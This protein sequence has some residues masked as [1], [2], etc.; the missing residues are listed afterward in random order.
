MLCVPAVICGARLT[1]RLHELRRRWRSHAAG[2]EGLPSNHKVC[3]ITVCVCACAYIC[4]C[5]RAL[6]GLGSDRF[7]HVHFFQ[8]TG[9]QGRQ[10]SQTTT[11]LHI[12]RSLQQ[13][14]L[15]HIRTRPVCTVGINYYMCQ[16]THT[17]SIFS[18]TC[19]Y[20]MAGFITQ[21][22]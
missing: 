6:V 17:S 20:C 14:L 8:T 18:L 2:P 3:Y 10:Q 19:A 9:V 22:V 21:G 12:H 1:S 7:L 13:Q 11:L 4:I 16:Y 5:L 15:C